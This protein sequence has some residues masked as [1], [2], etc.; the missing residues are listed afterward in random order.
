MRNEAFARNEQMIVEAARRAG[1]LV[2]EEET[3]KFSK[4]DRVQITDGF[5][6]IGALATVE[7]V[8]KDWSGIVSY[9]LKEFT[10]WWPQSGLKETKPG[11]TKI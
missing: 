9:K 2:D 4:G 6:H 10:G 3:F 7:N 11:N 1:I 8:S 5:A